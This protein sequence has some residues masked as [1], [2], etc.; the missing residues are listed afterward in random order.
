MYH[1]DSPANVLWLGMGSLRLS[2]PILPHTHDEDF[3]CPD[4]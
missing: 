2:T 1:N 3:P 4:I